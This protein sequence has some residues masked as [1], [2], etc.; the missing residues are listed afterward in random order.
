MPDKNIKGLTTINIFP[1]TFDRLTLNWNNIVSKYLVA[2]LAELNF[3]CLTV[4]IKL[5]P[6]FAAETTPLKKLGINVT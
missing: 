1:A 4:R 6:S 5:K 3:A 2:L